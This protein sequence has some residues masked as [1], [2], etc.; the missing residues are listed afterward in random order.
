MTAYY[1]QTNI[2][3]IALL[4]VVY[5]RLINRRETISAQRLTFKYLMLSALVMCVS[6]I[7]AWLCM[8]RPGAGMV[9]MQELFNILYDI[10]IVVCCFS[11]MMYVNFRVNGLEYD[12]KKEMI[13]GAIPMVLITLLICT[14][15]LTGLMFT[16]DELNNYSRGPGLWLH[17][18]VSWGYLIAAE[19]KVI[20]KL[21]KTKSRNAR[22]K[23]LPLLSFLAAPAAAAVIQMLCYGVTIMQCG[24]TFSIMLITYGFLQDKVSLDALTGLNNRSALE[25][26]LNDRIDKE[27]TR[28]MFLMCD[29]DRFKLI[30]DTLGHLMGDLALKAISDVL[31]G[32]CGAMKAGVFLCRY[33][34]D[35]F[36]ICSP[37]LTENETAALKNSIRDALA[38]Y[39]KGSKNVFALEISLGEACGLCAS[40]DDAENL[41]HEADE[42]MYEDKMSR[43]AQRV[44]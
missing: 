34:G 37:E 26:Y 12:H 23:L 2:F 25:T 43:R 31:K 42:R 19:L 15:P 3:C 10:A 21:T 40:Y 39:N 7:F 32:V 11:W 28:F 27:G 14:N 29:V 35:E 24:I 6:D 4:L 13:F 20:W 38:A 16:V 1:L 8:G 44:E 41:I 18:V 36:I 5:R 30:N 33:G 9:F 22:E 17:W